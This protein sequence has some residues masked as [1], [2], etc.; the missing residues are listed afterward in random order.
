MF[1]L[2]DDTDQ[3]ADP[4]EPKQLNHVWALLL[5]AR[6][7]AINIPVLRVLVAVRSEVWRRLDDDGSGQRDQVD[8]LRPLVVELKASDNFLRQVLQRSGVAPV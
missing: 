7:L 3:V 2:L 6:D 8:H 1:L 4:N 5:A